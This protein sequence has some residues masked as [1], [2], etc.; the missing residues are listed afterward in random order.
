MGPPVAGVRFAALRVS[1]SSTLLLSKSSKRTSPWL[2]RVRDGIS[3]VEGGANE[4]DEDAMMEAMELAL[5]NQKS[6]LP[7]KSWWP[8]SI[9]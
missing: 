7:S 5:L 3:M 8:K 9:C 2:L 4:A 1:L 6:S